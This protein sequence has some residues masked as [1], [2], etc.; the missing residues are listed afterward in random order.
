M[1]CSRESKT[2][3]ELLRDFK[4]FTSKKLIGMLKQHPGE[5]RKEWLMH[6]F[7]FFGK[8]N[9]AN[10]IFQFWEN[11]SHPIEFPR[12]SETKNGMHSLESRKSR[13]C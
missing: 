5:S 10:E 8:G 9:A 2:V 11:G 4:S 7:R 3:N 6:M 13:I 1:I 12:N